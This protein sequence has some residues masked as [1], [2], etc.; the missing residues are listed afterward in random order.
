[1]L[2][3]EAKLEYTRMYPGDMPYLR[4]I[5]TRKQMPYDYVSSELLDILIMREEI[6]HFYRPREKKWVSVKKDLIRGTG[7]KYKGPERRVLSLV[8]QHLRGFKKREGH[9]RWF[10]RLCR[11]LE[12]STAAWD[13]I[14]KETHWKE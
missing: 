2:I 9:P 10:E 5:Y 4:V 11:D 3:R 14:R 8:K 13:K 1:M 12:E 6:S 7:G